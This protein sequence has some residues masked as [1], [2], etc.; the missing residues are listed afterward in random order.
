MIAQAALRLFDPG[1]L[2]EAL[3]LRGRSYPGV[4]WAASVLGAGRLLTSITGVSPSS[5]C[6]AAPASSAET[7]YPASY[8]SR[9]QPQ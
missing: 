9:T 1:L 2:R 8:M 3:A 4:P 5:W 7:S 6:P